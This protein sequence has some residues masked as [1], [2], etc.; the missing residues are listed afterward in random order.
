MQNAIVRFGVPRI[1]Q[2]QHLTTKQA[3]WKVHQLCTKGIVRLISAC[4]SIN[5]FLISISFHRS[6]GLPVWNSKFSIRN[7]Q[8]VANE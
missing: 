8:V 2:T 1:D 4:R 6:L 5:A 3:G 7:V